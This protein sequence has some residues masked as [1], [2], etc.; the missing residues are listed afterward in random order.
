LR[1]EKGLLGVEKPGV[2]PGSEGTGTTTLLP[3]WAAIRVAIDPAN[4]RCAV[5]ASVRLELIAGG[6][7]LRLKRSTT[8]PA[9]IT[10]KPAATPIASDFAA[11]AQSPLLAA[12]LT[13]T[14]ELT[15]ADAELAAMRLTAAPL[16]AAV[17]SA[18]QS[19]CQPASTVP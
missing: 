14:D 7:S 18:T 2:A 5:G 4:G 13:T 11:A 17:W 16:A 19:A 8:A 9:P 6:A 3:G 15:L 12:L 1:V 10:A